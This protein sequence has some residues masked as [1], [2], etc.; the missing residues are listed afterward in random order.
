MPAS[1]TASGS[2]W[3][4]ASAAT[5]AR[6]RA[7]SRTACPAGTTWR[8]VGEIEGGTYP[9]TQR[10]HL[11]MSCNHC[12]EPL[13]LDG[14]PDRRL[15]EA[16]ERRRRPPR[17]RLHRLPVLHLGLPL[18]RAGLPA[19]PPHRHQVRPVQPPAR[20]RPWPRRASPP[21]PPTPSPSRRSTSRPGG[22][23]TRPPTPRSCR[24]RGS[25]SRP[26]ASSC[27]PYV[28]V[29]TFA[30]SDWNLR[31]EHPHWPLVWLT[32]LSQ[33][34]VGVSAT[35]TSPSHRLL[36]A[37]LAGAA[38]AGA[39]LHLGRPAMAWKALRGLRTS[40]LSREV[41][42]ARRLRRARRRGRR[43][44]GGDRA[45]PP[46]S[47]SP[48]STRRPASTSSRAGRRGTP[49]SPRSA[50]SP[51]SPPPARSLTGRPRRG[52]R[53]A[54]PS[55]S[56]PPPPTGSASPAS[57]AAASRGARSGSSSVRFRWWTVLRWALALGG[58]AAAVAGRGR[59]RLR[60]S[61]VAGELVGRWLF[62]VTVVPL[63]M[64]GSFWRGTAATRPP[65]SILEPGQGRVARG[66]TTAATGTPTSTT[67]SSGRSAPARHPS[68]GCARPAAT[69]RSAA[70]CCSASATG[71]AVAVAG[72]PAHPVNRGRLC[73]KG[74]SEHHTIGAPGRLTTPIV[75]GRAGLLGRRARPD[76]R[77][78]PGP[79]SSATAPRAS[80]C[81]P[82]ASSSPRSSTP[83]A[84]WCASA[85][86]SATSTATPPCAWPARCRATSSASAPTARPAATTTSTRP[87]W[88]CSGAPT[89][90]TT[91]RC[92]M[93]RVLA[94]PGSAARRWSP[95]TRG[96]RRRR[97]SPTSTSPSRPRGDIALLNGILR[98]LLDEGLVDPAAHAGGRRRPRRPPRPP[99]GLARRARAA[100]ESGIPA[101]QLVAVARTIG[102][103]DA[104]RARLDDGREPLGAGHRDR[105]PAQHPRRAHRQHR[106]ARRV[107]VLDHRPVQRHGH[108]GD[109]L[110]RVDAGLPR[111][112]RPGGPRR[113]RRAARHRRGPPPGRAGPGLPGHHQRGHVGDRSRASGSSPPTPWSRSPTGRCSSRPSAAS[114]CWSCR[115]ASRPPPRRSPTSCCRRRSGARRTAR[116]PTASAGCPGSGRRWRRRARPA[117]TST[118]CWRVAERWGCRDELFAGWHR[119]ARRLRR[120]AAGVR[121]PARATTA[122]S[123]GSAS[124]RP[125]ACSGRARPTTTTLPARRHAP[126][127]HRRPL[128]PPRRPPGGASRRAPSPSA[129]VPGADYPLLLNTGR[130]VEHWHTR[131]KTGRVPILEALAPEAWIEVNPLDADVAR[132]PL[133]PARPG[134]L[135]PGRGREHPGPGDADGAAPARCSSRSTGTSGAPTG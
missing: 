65:M 26:R 57:A 5:A 97:W 20:G 23:T 11:S 98:V 75:D 54:P 84:S 76:G 93:P 118:S 67:R 42:A 24:R 120:V 27:R 62:F 122:A 16:R 33:L 55:P 113:A 41:A 92:S 99:R 135:G 8:R 28:P 59:R 89:S 115:T 109:R 48:A 133:R 53:S 47:A 49:R 31:P 30:A 102:R 29:E 77:R 61:L 80:P 58:V 2:R 103:A 125:A 71:R 7:P 34:A 95:S 124:R 70:G 3:T 38:L 79:S 82:P 114:T 52:R 12:L 46:S 110:H 132:R 119:P 22:P 44:A 127:L 1:S 91:T 88:S 81:S 15:R 73:P 21:A 69:A 35:A 36:A 66:S 64:P 74:L 121:R 14:V 56:S 130:T 117:P 116:S 129:T 63:N 105:H 72:D 68:G 78:L 128:P 45:R 17:R 9:E 6:S 90:P 85:W 100:E 126:P 96:S 37:V 25:R 101:E 51:P 83:S 123:P 40:W 43:R 10:F 106:P 94:A 134:E 87:T 86:A 32:L 13:C 60:C 39:L 18:Q 50:S 104:L 19:R 107:A 4:R 108:P 131:T 111:L 112:R